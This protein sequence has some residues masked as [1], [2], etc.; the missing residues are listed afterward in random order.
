M[1]TPYSGEPWDR[2]KLWKFCQG[3]RAS[4]PGAVLTVWRVGADGVRRPE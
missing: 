2:L 3:L 4:F 1:P